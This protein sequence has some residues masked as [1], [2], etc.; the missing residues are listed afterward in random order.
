MPPSTPSSREPLVEN[1]TFHYLVAATMGAGAFLLLALLVV[2]SF[3]DRAY[4]VAR[5]VTPFAEYIVSLSTLIPI[6]P[7]PFSEK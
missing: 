5:Q 1:R 4:R 2:W 3:L 7:F 6:R